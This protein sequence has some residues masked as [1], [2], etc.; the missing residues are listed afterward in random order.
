MQIYE[1]Y[2]KK[3]NFF[4]FFI[5]NQMLFSVSLLILYLFT[6]V[7]NIFFLLKLNKIDGMLDVTP[8]LV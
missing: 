5:N 1:L 4:Y 7:F 3:L 8:L 2:P 6:F